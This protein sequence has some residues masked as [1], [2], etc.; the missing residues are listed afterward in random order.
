MTWAYGAITATTVMGE[1]I[2][3]EGCIWRDNRG[4][5]YAITEV[6]DVSV[7]PSGDPEGYKRARGA[8]R[9]RDGMETPEKTI[10]RLRDG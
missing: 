10:R 3:V 8:I 1:Q 9:S 2:I 7:R 5:I 6:S 4:N